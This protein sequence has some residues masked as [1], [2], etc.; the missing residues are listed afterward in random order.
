VSTTEVAIT[1]RPARGV[2]GITGIRD[3]AERHLCCGCGTCA[4]VQPDAVHMVDA[5]DAGRRPMVDRG[6]DTS[7]ALAACPGVGIA[8]H[9]DEHAP[10]V[11]PELLGAWGPVIEVWEGYAADDA[12]RLAGSSG[13]AA[14]ALALHAITHEGMHGVLHTAARTD[15]PYLNRT[16]MSHTRDELLAATGSRYAPASPC[17]G[18]GEVE[19]APDPCVFIGKPCDVAGADKARR[20]RPGLDAKLGLTIA[21]FC[22]G[23]PSTAGTLEMIRKMGVDDP[24]RVTGVRY[25]GDGW[26]GMAEVRAAGDPEGTRRQLTYDQ[27]WGDILQKHR[28]WRCQVC[29]DHTGELA[30]V[31]VGDPWYREIPPGEPGRSLVLVRTERGREVVRRAIDRG[32]LVLERVDPSVVERSQPNLLHVRGAVWGRTVAMRALGAPAPRYENMPTFPTWLRRLTLKQK[33]QSLYGT[34]KRVLRR[35]LRNRKPVVPYEPP[36]PAAP[37]G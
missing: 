10:G 5:L 30:D 26:P 37:P 17:D 28:Q 6:A 4:Y 21:M 14:T 25:R 29:A 13:G 18:L 31:A 35:G 2:R 8:H 32:A 33:A 34:G 15:V 11:L 7:L 16:V 9:P 12:I 22:A 20:L 3:V 23:T 1:R 36:L 24:A 27:S 19:A